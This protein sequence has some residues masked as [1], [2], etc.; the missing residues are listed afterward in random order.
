MLQ[1]LRFSGLFFLQLQVSLKTC[2]LLVFGIDFC[3]C[4]FSKFYA[5]FDGLMYCE[6]QFRHGLAFLKFAF[7]VI[8]LLV[9]CFIQFSCE[10]DFGL[11]LPLNCLF[12][13]C[14]FKFTASLLALNHV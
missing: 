10:T 1:T 14:F 2:G 9:F 4:L 13:A 7:F 8:C 5:T 12:S 3:W 11:A 6:T